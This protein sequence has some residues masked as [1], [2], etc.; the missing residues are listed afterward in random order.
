MAH[1]YTELKATNQELLSSSEQMVILQKAVTIHI[2]VK[3]R[4][5]K[6]LG[7]S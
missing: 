6:F 5:I 4:K 3:V 1:A 7:S 2:F